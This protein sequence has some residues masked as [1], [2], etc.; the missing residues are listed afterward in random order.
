MG[1]RARR[2][3][4]GSPDVTTTFGVEGANAS[5]L[6]VDDADTTYEDAAVDVDVLTNDDDT[7]GDELEITAVT[8]P[9][10]GTATLNADGTIRF[11]PAPDF[12]GLATFTYTV[13]DGLASS[14][15]TVSVTVRAVNDAP[16]AVAD[17]ATVAEDGMIEV[18]ARLNDSAGPANEGAQVLTV[19]LLTQPAH[20]SAVVLPSGRVEYRPAANYF[21]PDSLDYRVCDDGTTAGAPD[22]RCATST[23]S[24]TVTPVNDPPVAADDAAT[25]D[26]GVAVDV[27]VLANDSDVDGDPL[28]IDA[29]T[30]PAASEGTVTQ[31]A[32]GTLHF[33]PAPDF[34][35]TTTFSYTV[36]DGQATDEGSVSVT[37]R[38][39]ND[40]PTA[41]NDAATVA[42]D[43]VVSLDPRLNDSPG[44]ANESG[45]TLAVTLL[46]APAHGSA[47]VLPSGLVEYRPA[48][49]YF[50]PDSVGYRVCDDGTT[51]G[52][53]DPKCA[54]ATIVFTVTP[55]NDSPVAVDDSAATLGG[56]LV[57]VA[58][59]ANDTDVDGDVLTL[60]S[61]TQPATGQ[62]AVTQ[63]GPGTLRYTPAAG[64]TGT[65]TFAYVVSDGN[66]GSDGGSVSVTVAPRIEILDAS[67]S[68]GNSGIVDAVFT[69]RLTGASPTAVTA[70]LTTSNGTATAGAD[71]EAT[72]GTVTIPAGTLSVRYP[73]TSSATCSTSRTRRSRPRS[74]RRAALRSATGSRRGRS[75]TTIRRLRSPS[76]TSASS[77][78]TS[79]RR[80]WSSRSR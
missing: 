44:P 20:G 72:T 64:F 56:V 25:T 59:L 61:F 32:P 55:V 47:V 38:A 9:A 50:G 67:V 54:D 18:D 80:R 71:Y 19:E 35:G 78:A 8:Q 70:T 75:S 76:T 46:G 10:A 36:S 37:V 2:R 39:A 45:Q 1:R 43:G 3:G 28:T 34:F 73:S 42:E 63:V 31:T 11:T 26:E 41:V 52:A 40:A 33:T 24:F 17:S 7:D 13:S 22:P 79:A 12:F 58:V 27:P 6:A 30:Q 60:G 62:G 65:A 14:T 48:A 23:I 57:D 49:N 5:P 68:E 77:R 29:F 74:P 51:A 16:V 53:P 21:G 15:A 69:V 4:D 66:G